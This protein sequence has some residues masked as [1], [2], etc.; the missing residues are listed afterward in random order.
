MDGRDRLLPFLDAEISECLRKDSRIWVPSFTSA[1]VCR[2]RMHTEWCALLPTLQSGK[3]LEMEAALFA[4]G[5]R[6]AVDKLNLEKA[7]VDRPNTS[8]AISW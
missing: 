5:R 4:A 3:T 6:G 1:S 2:N 7:G 8:A